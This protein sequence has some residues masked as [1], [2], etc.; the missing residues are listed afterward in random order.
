MRNIILPKTKVY[1]DVITPFCNKTK[2]LKRANFYISEIFNQSI[3]LSGKELDKNSISN[4]LEENFLNSSFDK[5][6]YKH[7][8]IDCF[9]FFTDLYSYKKSSHNKANKIDAVRLFSSICDK[10]NNPNLESFGIQ[11]IPAIST[12]IDYIVEEANFDKFVK[13]IEYTDS[14]LLNKQFSISVT[15]SLKLKVIPYSLDKV[16]T[17][18]KV[19]ESYCVA[20]PLYLSKIIEYND[21]DKCKGLS[22]SL[23]GKKYIIPKDLQLCTIQFSLSY[24]DAYAFSEKLYKL[25]YKEGLESTNL[26]WL[27]KNVNEEKVNEK[28]VSIV[29][30]IIDRLNN[31]ITGKYVTKCKDLTKNFLVIFLTELWEGKSSRIK[32]IFDYIDSSTCLVSGIYGRHCSVSEAKYFSGKNWKQKK[33]QATGWNEFKHIETRYRDIDKN[34]TFRG[35]NEKLQPSS[36]SDLLS[37]YVDFNM[38]SLVD[39]RSKKNKDNSGNG[40]TSLR[41][42]LSSSKNYGTSLDDLTQLNRFDSKDDE[43]FVSSKEKYYLSSSDNESRTLCNHLYNSNFPNITIR[44]LYIPYIGLFKEKGFID[45]YDLKYALEYISP[46]DNIV[47]QNE[48]EFTKNIFETFFDKRTW[49]VY[50]N[51]GKRLISVSQFGRFN[52]NFGSGAT[53]LDILKT[54]FANKFSSFY[55][56]KNPSLRLIRPVKSLFVLLRHELTNA[57]Q[58]LVNFSCYN[59]GRG[60]G[61]NNSTYSLTNAHSKIGIRYKRL[62]NVFYKR[63]LD[64]F[65]YLIKKDSDNPKFMFTCSLQNME[66]LQEYALNFVDQIE[67][68]QSFLKKK[69]SKN[70]DLLLERFIS[71]FV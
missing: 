28:I 8:L 1:W 52:Y 31:F 29:C 68:I 49:L 50:K 20:N 36:L 48:L 53:G 63:F 14:D 19:Y 34:G 47:L 4:K 27:A 58:Y 56:C 43:T 51:L 71:Y 35:L 7:S 59:V 11:N 69:S 66:H 42:F 16:I 5:T 60:C 41:W 64:K 17:N 6:D 57:C 33:L 18:P 44:N 12:F 70:I 30:K 62:E 21:N 13:D 67:K 38:Q 54:K 55:L 39:V 2:I 40:I 23:N 24:L 46:F 3:G 45:S 22:I 25:L 10:D 61:L 32:K 65:K 37:R 15:S 26:W 9:N